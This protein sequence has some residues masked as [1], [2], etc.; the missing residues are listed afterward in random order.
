MQCTCTLTYIQN[1]CLNSSRYMH[2][3]AVQA[4]NHKA[5]VCDV[6]VG[7]DGEHEDDSF[8]STSFDTPDFGQTSNKEWSVIR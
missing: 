4:P 7:L 5:L 2:V 8:K 1:V 3:V 6:S